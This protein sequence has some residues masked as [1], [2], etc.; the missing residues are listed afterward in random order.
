MKRTSSAPGGYGGGGGA[1]RGGGG[2]SYGGRGGGG[3]QQPAKK[4]RVQNDD[5]DESGFM[6]EEEFDMGEGQYERIE[7][8]EGEDAAS[9]SQ[10]GRWIRQH[11]VPHDST[12]QPLIVHW[13]DIDMI[14]GPPL[15]RNP[16]GGDVIGSTDVIVPIVR[17]Y[18][19][20]Q[21]GHSAMIHVHGVTP[22]FYASFAGF[23]DL[24]D[25]NLGLIRSAMDLKVLELRMHSSS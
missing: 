17:L 23:S 24:S 25:H 9:E 6:P 21:E 22:Y 14:S 8:V 11:N 10:S 20:T 18:G 5:F 16:A 12:T 13:L 4:P 3:A 2:G 19:V 15:I 1:G 7:G